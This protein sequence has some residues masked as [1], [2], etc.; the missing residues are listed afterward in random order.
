MSNT[1]TCTICGYSITDPVCR[2]CYIKQTMTYLNDFDVDSKTMSI[3]YLKLKKIFNFETINE[4]VCILCHKDKVSICGYCF[5]SSLTKILRKLNFNEETIENFSYNPMIE[6]N[7]D[8]DRITP[9]NIS[10][11]NDFLGDEII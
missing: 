7:E 3:I 2:G 4:S 10:L 5:Y 6:E 11:L 8:Y 1:T 9:D